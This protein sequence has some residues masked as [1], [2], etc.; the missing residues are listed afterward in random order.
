MPNQG[1]I[2]KSHENKHYLLCDLIAVEE[3]MYSEE[4][5]FEG[6]NLESGD[7]TNRISICVDKDAPHYVF[8]EWKKVA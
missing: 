8:F 5:R 3:N 2:W 6:Y 4:Y 7:F 1:E